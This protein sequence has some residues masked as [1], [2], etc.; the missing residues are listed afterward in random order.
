MNQGT[1]NST[2]LN[3][4]DLRELYVKNVETFLD[5]DGQ[6]FKDKNGNELQVYQYAVD[7]EYDDFA[8]HI[9]ACFDRV[10]KDLL[11][12][13]NI[14]YMP[15]S[16]LDDTIKSFYYKNGT[17]QETISKYTKIDNYGNITDTTLIPEK[18]IYCNGYYDYN[19]EPETANY[20]SKAV[21]NSPEGLLFWFDFLDAE[22]SE[23]VKYSVPLIGPRQLKI[24]MLNLYIIEK[25]QL[26]FSKR[27]KKYTNIR[28]DILMY[29]FKILWKIYLQLVL[30]VSLRKRELKN[31]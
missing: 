27:E 26:L 21:S 31:I 16:E 6:T 5:K 22:N 17:Y 10:D 1:S 23:I 7:S 9:D 14:E 11:Y 29:N 15:F 8:R 4:V 18:I 20:W 24:L 3:N 25:F 30:R 13:R 2:I 28:L 12:I 19:I